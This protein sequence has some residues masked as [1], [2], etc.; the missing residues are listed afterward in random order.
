MHF[1]VVADGLDHSRLEA[2]LMSSASMS[3]NSVDIAADILLRGI[4]PAQD[5]FDLGILVVL[6]D[7]KE[8]LVSGLLARIFRD[9][10]DVSNNSIGMMQFVS[11]LLLFIVEDNRQTAVNER[12]VFKMLP[13]GFPIE[14]GAAKN[15]FVRTKENHRAATTKRFH[16][17]NRPLRLASMK[18]LHPFEA[19][20]VNCRNHFR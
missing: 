14:E 6:C 2:V 8:L 13:N 9:F 1:H 3:T 12:D 16:L 15:L 10:L 4:S 11:F 5:D 18:C 7:S 20:A 17:F 19:I